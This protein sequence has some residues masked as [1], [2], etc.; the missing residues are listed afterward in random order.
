[1]TVTIPGG[2]A[3]STYSLVLRARGTNSDGYSVVHVQPLT[4]AVGTSAG[5]STKYVN[6]QGYGVFIITSVD[7]NVVRGRA[8]SASFADPADPALKLARRAGLLPW[9]VA[10]Y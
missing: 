7:T 6:V 10:P 2:L 5:G 1:V 4:L 3:Q 9:E 8:I